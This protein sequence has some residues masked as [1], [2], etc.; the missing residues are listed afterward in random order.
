MDGEAEKAEELLPVPGNISVAPREP[1]VCLQCLEVPG[2]EVATCNDVPEE[3]GEGVGDNQ[4]EDEE[5]VHVVSEEEVNAC[6]PPGAL[7]HRG[8][9]WKL[10]SLWL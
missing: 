6:A 4:Q 1:I 3:K 8:A 7:L 5:Y 2:A 10:Q 9:D